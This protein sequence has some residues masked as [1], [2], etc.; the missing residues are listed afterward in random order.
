MRCGISVV[1]VRDT[2]GVKQLVSVCGQ[3]S[4]PQSIHR[5]LM[6]TLI[7][8]CDNSKQ[9]GCDEFGGQEPGP[10]LSCLGEQS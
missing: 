5:D 2:T 10:E 3:R 8:D 6:Q 7:L 9:E 4:G 1:E